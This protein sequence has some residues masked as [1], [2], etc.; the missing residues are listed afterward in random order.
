[1]ADLNLNVNFNAQGQPSPTEI[2]TTPQGPQDTMSLT[3]KQRL[4]K[5][6]ADRLLIAKAAWNVGKST[7]GKFGAWTG[8]FAGQKQFNAGIKFLGYG[9]GIAVSPLAGSLLAGSAAFSAVVD[10]GLELRDDRKQ[11]KRYNQ[12]TR[13]REN[14]GRW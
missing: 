12:V 6:A 10:V 8:N 3:E 14:N 13:N 11:L 7:V 9:L 1:M 4:A 2:N 5:A